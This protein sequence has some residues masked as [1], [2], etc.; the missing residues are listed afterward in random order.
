MMIIFRP[1]FL[2]YIKLKVLY[3]R[4]NTVY[5]TFDFSIYKADYSLIVNIITI[6]IKKRV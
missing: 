4:D 1:Y 3:I 6:Q 2:E 5:L